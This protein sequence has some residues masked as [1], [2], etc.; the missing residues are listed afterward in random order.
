VSRPRRID[1]FSYLGPHRYVV[2]FCT[3]A[4]RTLF[5]DDQA[6]SLAL[7]QFRRVAEDEGFAIVAHCLM[8]DHVHLLPEGVT[9]RA[10]L[11]RFVKMA[12]QRTA[13]VLRSEFGLSKVCQEGYHDW[14]LR[15]DQQTEDVIRYL[16]D[17]P[18]R[19]GLVRQWQEYPYS[20]TLYSLA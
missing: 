11:R 6:A 8:P 15:N 16:L 5:T 9:K 13:H 12:K 2:T 7:E 19:A 17:N 4:R 10:D 18:V 20:G 3:H 1:G 14:V